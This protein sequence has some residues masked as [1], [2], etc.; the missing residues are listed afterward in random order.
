MHKELILRVI[1]ARFSE[2]SLTELEV[3]LK[4]LGKSRRKDGRVT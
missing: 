4:E 2:L 1:E 3:V